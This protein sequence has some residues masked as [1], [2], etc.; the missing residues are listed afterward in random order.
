MQIDKCFIFNEKAFYKI[1]ELNKIEPM[2]NKNM[3]NKF[4]LSLPCSLSILIPCYYFNS[5]NEKQLFRRQTKPFC[6]FIQNIFFA[7]KLDKN[8]K[9]NKFDLA[10]DN[11]VPN[12]KKMGLAEK[13]DL[14]RKEVKGVFIY[15]YDPKK[16]LL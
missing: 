14:I 4:D 8:V 9:L 6:I 11:R 3:K 5:L 10:F 13:L 12:A 15:V 1:I 7:Y 2:L 16:F